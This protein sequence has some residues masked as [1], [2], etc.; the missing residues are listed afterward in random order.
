[1][2]AYHASLPS[3][4]GAPT[5]HPASP[6][7]TS[8][9]PFAALHELMLA[10]ISVTTALSAAVPHVLCVGGLSRQKWYGS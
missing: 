8:R 5:W 4:D 3:R 2:V 9:P 1:M 10:Y 6:M 7:S